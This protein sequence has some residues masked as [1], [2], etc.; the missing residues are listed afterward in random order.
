[1]DECENLLRHLENDIKGPEAEPGRISAL[2]AALP[3][4]TVTAPRELSATLRRRLDEIADTHGGTI[5]LHGRLFAQWMHHAYPRE[6]Q[7]P[8]VAGTTAPMAALA[9]K[10]ESGMNHTASNDEIEVI[11]QEAELRKNT[12][13]SEIAAEDEISDLMPWS[14]EE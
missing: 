7:Y 6:C 9:W 12:S 11:V 8:H 2:V 13:S 10:Q 14:Y 5:P 4:A 1:M 3:S